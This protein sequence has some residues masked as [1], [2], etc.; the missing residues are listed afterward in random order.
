VQD[1][2]LLIVWPPEMTK[3]TVRFPVFAR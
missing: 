1:G 2:K 3:H